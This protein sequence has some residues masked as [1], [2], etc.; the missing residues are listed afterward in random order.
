[1]RGSRP[2]AQEDAQS[3]GPGPGFFQG[4]HLAQ[5]HQRGKFAAFADY[6]FRGRGPALHRLPHN[7]AGQLL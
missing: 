5:P 1:M 7:V 6:R 4:F 3:C 2:L